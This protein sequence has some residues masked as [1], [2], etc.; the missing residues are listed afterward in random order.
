LIAEEAQQNA[1]FI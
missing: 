1:E